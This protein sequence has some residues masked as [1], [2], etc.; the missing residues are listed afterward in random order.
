VGEREEYSRR[1]LCLASALRCGIASRKEE[2]RRGVWQKRG[3]QSKAR[4]AISDAQT[5]KQKN[6]M[7]Q[8]TNQSMYE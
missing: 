3:A 5:H 7:A 8:G 4:K 6:E 1:M 2:D